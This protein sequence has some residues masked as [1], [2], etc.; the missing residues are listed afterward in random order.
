MSY[1]ETYVEILVNSYIDLSEEEK[2]VFKRDTG[3]TESNKTEND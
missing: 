3:L 2:E 1:R